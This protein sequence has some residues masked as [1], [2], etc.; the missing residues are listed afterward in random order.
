MCVC[1]CVCYVGTGDSQS[2]HDK[3][4]MVE[5]DARRNRRG[6]N[7]AKRELASS[8]RCVRI[9]KA[10]RS[11]RRSSMKKAIDGLASLSTQATRHPRKAER[12]TNGAN[13]SSRMHVCMYA[14][15]CVHAYTCRYKKRELASSR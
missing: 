10:T 9:L 13:V 1:V 12:Y 7:V 5:T 11:Q 8:A 2:F 6:R 3:G 4:I 14:R 15:V